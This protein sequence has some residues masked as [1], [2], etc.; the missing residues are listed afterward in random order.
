M[1]N[2]Y[3]YLKKYVGHNDLKGTY[4][5][6]ISENEI[7]LAEEKMEKKFPDQLRSFYQEIGSGILSC[8]VQY[9]EMLAE[10]I[11]N[12]ILPPRIAADYMLGILQHPED[13]DYYMAES[14]YELLELGDLPFFEIGDS[15]SFMIMKLNSENP[16]AVWFMGHE[17]IEDSFE[18]FIW[19][20]YYNDP[21]YYAKNW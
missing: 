5:F 6:S 15:S 14:A 16:N 3:E 13:N 8:G 9:P 10:S 21:S 11:D 1:S 2:K 7:K 17:K 18:K 20:L 4:F 12:R 19:N